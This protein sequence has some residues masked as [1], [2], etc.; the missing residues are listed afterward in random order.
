[1]EARRL[2]DE[3]LKEKIKQHEQ[4]QREAEEAAMVDAVLKKTHEALKV[5]RTAQ[6]TPKMLVT[7]R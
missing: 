1:M 6:T 3:A 2:G 4:K 5:S 7:I